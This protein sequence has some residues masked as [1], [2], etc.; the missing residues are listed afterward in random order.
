MDAEKELSDILTAEILEE[1]NK[2]FIQTTK[3]AKMPSYSGYGV[4]VRQEPKGRTNGTRLLSELE[5]MTYNHGMYKLTSKTI[6]EFAA[7][8]QANFSDWKDVKL[9]KIAKTIE[10]MPYDDTYNIAYELY[11]NHHFNT[12]HKTFK[13]SHDS[14]GLIQ[15]FKF[16]RIFKLSRNP[17]IISKIQS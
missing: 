7:A 3:N 10:Y 15:I 16:S 11:S 13:F 14:N 6:W 9:L 17:V 12:L 1:A 8:I 5:N 2:G 4:Q